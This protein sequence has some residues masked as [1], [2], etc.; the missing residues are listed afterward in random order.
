MAPQPKESFAGCHVN[1]DGSM[2]VQFNNAPIPAMTN[3][4]T[5]VPDLELEIVSHGSAVDSSM[6]QDAYKIRAHHSGFRK[7]MSK[8]KAAIKKPFAAKHKTEPCH[9]HTIYQNNGSGLADPGTIKI[10][11]RP[12]GKSAFYLS[13]TTYDLCS[14]VS[15]LSSRTNSIKPDDESFTTKPKAHTFA[16][17]MKKAA[18]RAGPVVIALVISI[19]E[20][21]LNNAGF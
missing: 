17:H 11:T 10:S 15:G 18:K 20:H 6:G 2:D 14:I 13:P 3:A 4:A 5:P 19:A 21:Y 16:A 7:A 8:I 1:P 9:C 12:T